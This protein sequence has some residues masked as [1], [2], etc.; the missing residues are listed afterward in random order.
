MKNLFLSVFALTVIIFIFSCKRDPD[1]LNPGTT[2]DTTTIGIVTPIGTI[3]GEMV[4]VSIGTQGGTITSG[5]GRLQVVIPAGALSKNESISV[6]PVSNECPA[7]TGL[8]YRL[9]PHGLTFAQPATITFHYTEENLSGT[10][11]ELLKV[12][13]QTNTQSWNA[14]E[15][16][17]WSGP[18]KTVS[19]QTT[20]FSDWALFE[21][22]Q[23][24]E[25]NAFLS[26]GQKTNLTIRMVKLQPAS[27]PNG[28]GILDIEDLTDSKYIK[29]WTLQGEGTLAH[30][31]VKG[32]YF[33]PAQIPNQN[34]ATIIVFLDFSVT[35]NGEV[36][37]DLRLV[38][39]IF[40]APEGVSIQIGNG[41]WI[42]Y[43]GGVNLNSTQNFIEAKSGDETV[44][45]G[46]KGS[47]S[48]TYHWTRDLNVNFN[49]HKGPF[50]LYQHLYGMDLSV[51]GGSLKVDNSKMASIS[52]TFTLEPAGLLRTDPGHIEI[53]TTNIRGV[54]FLKKTQPR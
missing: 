38:S 35:I 45:I 9:L 3:Q 27:N 41:S 39:Q 23:L 30:Q 6:Q 53:G 10:T 37:R 25:D 34:P 4:T 18:T 54:F 52:G 32:T 13:Y 7:G 50:M 5:D 17:N 33:A 43:P 44:V 21:S 24:I 20:H 46:W 1:R 42:T 19:V 47:S 29:N 40:V 31:H 11:P 49:Y 51:S 2:P 15:N 22:M 8:A 48:G 14:I 16:H 26:P 28:I 12:A 36:F